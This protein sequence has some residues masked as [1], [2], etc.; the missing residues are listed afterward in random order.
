MKVW[1]PTCVIRYK[2][3]IWGLALGRA[4]MLRIGIETVLATWSTYFFTVVVSSPDNSL[5]PGGVELFGVAEWTYK[6]SASG[7]LVSISSPSKTSRPGRRKIGG[8]F[9]RECVLSQQIVPLGSVH[10]LVTYMVMEGYLSQQ[11][12]PNI[13]ENTKTDK[14][15]VDNFQ[16]C[17]FAENKR[18]CGSAPQCRTG[19][20]KWTESIMCFTILHYFILIFTKCH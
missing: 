17:F 14:I 4:S 1:A 16:R 3:V 6:L 2:S 10:T 20:V 15:H 8:V 18:T 13:D 7:Y 11:V 5:F 9:K 12:C 19:L